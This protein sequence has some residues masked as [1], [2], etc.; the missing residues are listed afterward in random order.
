MNLVRLSANV[1]CI[2]GYSCGWTGATHVR[3]PYDAA[4]VDGD[5]SGV[6]L[7]DVESPTDSKT[8]NR[9]KAYS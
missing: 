7:I 8:R 3:S 6:S 2:C 9:L 1:E 4:H 5:D